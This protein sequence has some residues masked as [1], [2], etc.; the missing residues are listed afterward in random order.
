[1]MYLLGGLLI[2]YLIILIACTVKHSK[3]KMTLKRGEKLAESRKEHRKKLKEDLHSELGY[4]F[5]RDDME[6][7][8]DKILMLKYRHYFD[9]VEECI[10]DLLIEM[11]DCGF[12]KTEELYTIAYGS[13]ALT[14]DSVVF[15]TEGLGLDGENDATEDEAAEEGSKSEL[16]PVSERAMNKIHAK[17]RTYVGDLLA[18][19]EIKSDDAIKL[20][21]IEGLTSYG[22]T[23]LMTLLHS[24]E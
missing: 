20:E 14:E 2:G 19:V 8:E 6:G 1:M 17:W 7:V 24:P 12:V 10:N 23:D 21:I 16:P 9:T 11:Y 13:D 5:N 4:W 3:N 22:Q 18:N 15:Q